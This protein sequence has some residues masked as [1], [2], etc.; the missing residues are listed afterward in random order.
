[1]RIVS[2]QPVDFQERIRARFPQIEVEKGLLVQGDPLSEKPLSAKAEPQIFR[3]G[4]Q[5]GNTIASLGLNFYALS[6]TAYTHWPEFLELVVFL[7]Q[8]T[9]EVYKLPYATRIGLR[10]INHLTFENTKVS[11]VGELWDIARPEITAMLRCECWDDPVGMSHQ[12]R[13]AGEGDEK[14]TLRTGFTGGQDPV[15]LLD[16]DYYVEGRILLDGLSELCERYHDVI[17]RA[18]RWCIQDGKLAVFK[19]VPVNEEV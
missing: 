11:S 9:S 4:S 5:D 1:L 3:F 13:L 8:V 19:P 12:L 10:Y 2:E 7:N 6:T 17:Y 15:F 18:F 16:F 14:L